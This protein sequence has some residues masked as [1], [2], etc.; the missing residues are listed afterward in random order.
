[1]YEVAAGIAI[2]P[3]K[4]GYK[5]ILIQPQPGG[6]FTSM[7]ASHQT[8]YGKVSSAWTLDGNSFDLAIEVPA[9]TTVTVKLPKTRL[10]TVTENGQVLG[11]GNGITDIMQAGDSVVIE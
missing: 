1:M 11:K 8:M 9:N 5:H 4:P 6:G 7:R 2:D 10:E 3:A